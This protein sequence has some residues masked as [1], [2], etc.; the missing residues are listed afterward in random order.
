M[1]TKTDFS[2]ISKSSNI[3]LH[4]I[5]TTLALLMLLP[6]V[7]VVIIS[8]SSQ[9]SIAENGYSFFPSELSLEAYKYVFSNGQSIMS[10]FLVSVIVTIGGTLLGS[11]LMSTYA[12]VLSRKNFRYVKFF[13]V[14][15]LIPMLFSGGMVT[16][17]LIMTTLLGLKDSLWAL[18]LPLLMSSFYIFVLKAFFQ[19]FVPEAIIESAK[20]DGAT[21]WQTFTKIVIPVGKPGIATIALFL[22]LG[23]WN[24]W[25]QAMLYIET[26]SKVPIQYL[27]IR[28]ENT[29]NFLKQMSAYMG[30]SV[31]EIAA[32]MPSDTL[33]MAVVVIVVLP[34]ALSYPYFQ[35]YFVQGLTVG[36]VKE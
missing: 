6:V 29:S 11:V 3:M 23:Y 7:F 15:A 10:S 5:F 14:V 26:Q 19:G 22:T 16:N 8:F 31:A 1:E 34:I 33:K 35:K 25:F 32:N 12:Y 28:M 2:Q 4:I 17:Y 21:E 13:T 30:A 18:I 36:A 24:D 9:N 27:L 20:V